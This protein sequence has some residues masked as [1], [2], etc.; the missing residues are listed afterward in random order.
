MTDTP[1]GAALGRPLPPWPGV[2]PLSEAAAVLGLAPDTLQKRVTRRRQPS[3]LRGGRRLVVLLPHQWATWAVSYRPPAGGRTGPGG[4]SAPPRTGT[5]PGPEGVLELLRQLEAANRRAAELA[6]L[7]GYWQG[8]VAELEA[9]AGRPSEPVL[10]A[11]SR[12]DT[13]PASPGPP[14]PPWWRRVLDWL[15]KPPAP[16]ASRA[17]SPQ[18]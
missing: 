2:L 3:L 15:G 6:G 13:P 12:P 8:R 7:L 10:P 14:P 17:P 11:D 9:R 1:A 16:A 4:E 18:R 5:D